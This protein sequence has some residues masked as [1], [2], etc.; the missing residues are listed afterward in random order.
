VTH[1]ELVILSH[2]GLQLTRN[3]SVYLG[4]PLGVHPSIFYDRTNDPL[5]LALLLENVAETTVVGKAPAS[6]VDEK[7][8]A[9]YGEG[10]RDEEDELNREEGEGED[11]DVLGRSES[12]VP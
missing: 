6:K 9:R 4:P 10:E 3:P 11:V 7:E 12:L 2:L 8:V 5:V 1:L